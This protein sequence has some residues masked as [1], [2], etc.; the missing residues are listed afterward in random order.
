M[1]EVPQMQEQF[2][3][4]PPWMAEVPQMQGALCGCPRLAQA[5]LGQGEPGADQQHG[6]YQDEPEPGADRQPILLER[7]AMLVFLA[8]AAGTRLV[9]PRM[10]AHGASATVPLF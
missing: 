1:A 7:A 10:V 6:R 4:R 9:A 8:A 2:C 5:D 3:G